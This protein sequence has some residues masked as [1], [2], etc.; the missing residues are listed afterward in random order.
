MVVVMTEQQQ[1]QIPPTGDQL[2]VHYRC[3]SHTPN[4]QS[5]LG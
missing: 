5:P 4:K 2:E 3:L 1:V